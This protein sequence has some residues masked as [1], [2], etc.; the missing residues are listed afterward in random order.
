MAHSTSQPWGPSYTPY[1]LKVLLLLT[2]I[3]SL[4]STFIPPLQAFLALSANTLPQLHLWQLI[5]YL[6]TDPFAQGFSFPF[7]I[8]VA[9]NLYLLWIFGT[10][11]MERSKTLFFSLYF[12][13][14]LVAALAVC[15]SLAL[16]HLPYH[17]GGS[18]TALYSLLIG[19]VILFPEAELLLFFAIP[20]KARWLILGLFAINFMIDLST[21]DWIHLITYSSS[22]LFGYLFLVFAWKEHSPFSGLQGFERSVHKFRE[23]VEV[24]W[25]RK[26]A[27]PAKI[28]DFHSGQPLSSDDAFMDTM[29]A[30]ISRQG[31]SSLTAEEKKRM[32]QISERKKG[33][34]KP[35]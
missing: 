10:S 1:P 30:K 28:Y 33:Y 7:C 23:R 13:G 4:L 17:L 15:A 21:Q 11:L 6:W 8:H 24:L 29:L 2:G 20:L 12:G 14:G 35:S 27:K 32:Q 9:F 22:L 18:S 26:T 5:T 31:E 3:L 34:K 25:K 16:F 19:W